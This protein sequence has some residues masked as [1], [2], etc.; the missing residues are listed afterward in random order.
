MTLEELE[1]KHEEYRRA[2]EAAR[3][4]EASDETRKAAADAAVAS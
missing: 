1:Q 4:E 2:V 3:D